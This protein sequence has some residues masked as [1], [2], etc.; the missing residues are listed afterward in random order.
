ML[1][2]EADKNNLKVLQ[3]ELVTSGSVNVYP[4]EFRL[5]EDWDGMNRV[6]V[7][8]NGIEMISIPLDGTNQCQIPWEVMTEPNR[9]LRVGIFGTEGETVVLPTIWA[10]L[11]IIQQGTTMGDEPQEPTPGIYQN[12]QR[13]IGNLADLTTEHRDSLVEALNEVHQSDAGFISSQQIRTIQVLDRGEYD[14]LME[15]DPQ[16]LYLIRG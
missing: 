2:L 1:I 10:N 3:K 4:V 16:T 6:A 15:K 9:Q 14:A 8:T 12:L 7:F 5:N 11:G 13:M